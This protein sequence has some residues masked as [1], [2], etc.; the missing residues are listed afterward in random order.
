MKAHHWFIVMFCCAAPLRGQAALDRVDDLTRFDSE[1]LGLHAD[2]SF[3]A[4]AT[5]FAAEQPAQGLLAL[6]DDGLA[7]RAAPI[8]VATV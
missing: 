4:D 3:M 8:G 7:V 2:L 1:A 6:L 5:L